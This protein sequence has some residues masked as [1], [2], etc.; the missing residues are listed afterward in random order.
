MFRRIDFSSGDSLL[1][2]VVF[3]LQFVYSVQECLVG[4]SAL[5]AVALMGALAV[6]ELQVTIQVSL[7]MS[8]ERGE[9]YYSIER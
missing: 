8:D 1:R 5:R 4:R 2:H 6:V 3:F 7:E 9:E